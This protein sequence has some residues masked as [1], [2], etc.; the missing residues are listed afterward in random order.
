[1]TTGIY[2]CLPSLLREVRT[3]PL[4]VMR[5]EL[6][7]V[8][9]RGSTPGGYRRVDMVAGGDFEGGRLAG[10]VLEGGDDWKD[11]RSGGGGTLDARLMLKTTDDALIGMAC[12]GLR[13][14]PPDLLARMEKGEFVDP[15][16]AYF[17]VAL[18][19]ET[20]ARQYDWL[21]NVLAVGVGHR[22][23]DGPVYSIF[24]IL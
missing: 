8:Q 13:N 18:H 11:I 19:F 12:G 10:R 9:R 4:F 2:F 17:R 7:K 15:A 24:E 1:M 14:R 5:L 20:E 23:P 6:R 21:N 16:D 22:N 3:K